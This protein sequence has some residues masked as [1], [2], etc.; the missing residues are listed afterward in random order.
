MSRA[1]Q[2]ALSDSDE[3]A[4]GLAGSIAA[5]LRKQQQAL[6]LQLASGGQP[7]EQAQQATQQAAEQVQEVPQQQ[8]L[9][10]PGTGPL[11]AS[12][13]ALPNPVQQR[14]AAVDRQPTLLSL[15]P[16][17]L[18]EPQPWEQQADTASGLL[19]LP[20]HLSATPW[21]QR[22]A[23][24]EP[25]P[26]WQHHGD[27]VATATEPEYSWEQQQPTAAP[28]SWQQQ[29]GQAQPYEQAAPPTQAY[30]PLPQ[31]RPEGDEAEVDALLSLLGIG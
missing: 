23:A 5:A 10:E 11:P 4:S 6:L 1:A 18:T 25:L 7:W 19:P 26:R 9:P 21:E 31:V 22:A 28:Y 12:G 24:A 17:L 20:P 2:D 8:S 13:L 29:Q 30:V 16:H 3:E 14:D 15:P 27:Q